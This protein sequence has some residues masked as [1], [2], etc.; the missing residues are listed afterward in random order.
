MYVA[1][2]EVTNASIME[3]VTQGVTGLLDLS[4]TILTTV[5]SNPVYA[6]FFAT[7]VAGIAFGLIRKSKRA[8]K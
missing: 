1:L 6:L 8:I 4:G 3:S 5:L 7:S 2:T